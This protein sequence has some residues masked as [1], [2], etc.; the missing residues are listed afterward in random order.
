MTPVFDELIA[1]YPAWWIDALGEHN[2]VGGAAS[3]KWLL[4]RSGLE[5]GQRMID[6][7][8][9]VGAT[10]RY[11]ATRTGAAAVAT[12]LS[13][14]FLRAGASMPGGERVQ[15]LAADTGRLPFADATFDSLWCLDSS[16]DAREMSRVAKPNA[17]ICL[18]SEIPAE[19]AG[20]I[21]VYAEWWQSSG[22]TVEE[23][24]DITADA[25]QTWRKTE[26]DLIRR[27][28]HFMARYG[29][30]GYREHL[31]MLADLIHTYDTRRQSHGL[32][33]LRRV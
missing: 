10:A 19:P 33:I 14:E 32:F 26:A 17:T 18:C 2:H 16:V 31:D 15:W 11:A 20:G 24:R 23:H 22:W 21:R 3:T 4:D 28:Q 8:A 5:Q 27:R 29:D 9:F 13:A 12:D 6:L 7:G 30:R 1:D 25:V